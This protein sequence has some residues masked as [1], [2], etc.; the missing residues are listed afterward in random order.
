MSAVREPATLLERTIRPLKA[1]ELRTRST[2]AQTVKHALLLL[3]VLAAVQRVMNPLHQ[4]KLL[5]KVVLF[6]IPAVGVIVTV[7]AVADD[8]R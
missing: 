5:R 8:Q 1:T 7:I 2:A 6:F 3:N 4:A